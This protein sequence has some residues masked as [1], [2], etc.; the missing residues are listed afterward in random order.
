MKVIYLT[1]LFV[2][3]LL[4]LPAILSVGI[5]QVPH[6]KQSGLGGTVKIYGNNEITEKLTCPNIQISSIGMSFKNP[7]LNNKKD[8]NL[9]ISDLNGYILSESKLNGLYIPDGAFRKFKLDKTLNCGGSEILLK[10]TSSDSTYN[11][12]LEA[13]LS[14][15]PVGDYNAVIQTDSSTLP[16]SIGL[17]MLSPVTNKVDL[18]QDI[19]I[20][21]FN[22]FKSDT[23]FAVIY[24][25]L[26]FSIL[27]VGIYSFL[28]IKD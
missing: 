24:L 8:I 2:L 26:I 23:S 13:L 10:L 19:Y 9:T 12:A 7:S 27:G 15:K 17:V 3:G 6:L 5:F 4:V 22:K 16:Q 18:A 20:N 21:F 1:G 25:I 14:D 28:K 11:D